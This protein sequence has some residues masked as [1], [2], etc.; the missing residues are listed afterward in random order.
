MRT[1]WKN[2]WQL[3]SPSQ[4]KIK[5]LIFLL[6]FYELIKLVSPF[7]LKIIIDTLTLSGIAELKLLLWLVAGMLAVEEF[8]SFIGW[9]TNRLIMKVIL[10]VEYYLPISAQK[11]MMFLPLGYHEREN[12]GNKITKVQRGVEHITNL[13]ENLFWE[14]LPTCLQLIITI[15]A[16]FFIDWRF[17]ISFFIFFPVFFYL[18]Y[19]ANFKLKSRRQEMHQKWEEASGKMA[20]SI[21][22][23]NAV[24]SF[25]QEQRETEEYKGIRDTILTNESYVWNKVMNFVA[26]RDF[27]INSGRMTTLVMGIWFVYSGLTTIG[28]LVFVFTISEKAFFSMFRLSRFYDRIE[29][30]LEPVERFI[31]LAKEE[32][33]IKNPARGLKPKNIN[34][35]VEFKDVTFAYE[36]GH[37]NALENVSLKIAAGTINAFV[38]PSGGGK[39]TIARLIYRHY[40]PQT[41]KILL[42]GRDLREYDL[43]HFRRAIAIVPQEV[44][45]FNA[46]VRDNISYANPRASFGEIK[47]A[48]RAANAEEFIDNLKEDY[49]TL[50]GERGIKLSG[51]QRQRIGIAR[52]ILANPKIL[53]FDE[54][55][56]NLDSQSERLIQEAMERVSERRTVIII[57]HRF[58]TIRHADQIFVLDRGELVEQG[59]HGELSDVQGGLYA[60]LLKLQSR[61]DVD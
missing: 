44:E 39:T 2:L 10:D 49:D 26:T 13:I 57:A 4:N 34:G 55:T 35:E 59:S 5:G 38:G 36:Q 7:L 37:I 17:S 12:T 33:E 48:A 54:A 51:G 45:I 31:N 18:T 16:L 58:S 61:G 27:L 53:I 50:A 52:A 46:S 22:N 24:Q 28:T 32:P 14:I 41:G 56:S 43:Y 42:D 60:K 25:V 15:I 9:I 3:V 21:M 20:Q 47:R 40:D 30:S 11:K 6:A 19:R 1:F 8:Q 23:I 29:H